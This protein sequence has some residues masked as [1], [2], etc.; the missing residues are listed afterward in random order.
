MLPIGRHQRHALAVVGVLSLTVLSA[1][2]VWPLVALSH[3]IAPL[4]PPLTLRCATLSFRPF[5][6]LY[7]L[8]P[9][10]LIPL[11]FAGLAWQRRGE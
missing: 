2:V 4:M 7:A 9:T 6:Y 8:L 5:P 1:C 3:V 10:I 11:A